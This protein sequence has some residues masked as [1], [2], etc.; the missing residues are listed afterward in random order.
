MD[1]NY[2][3]KYFIGLDYEINTINGKDLLI[4]QY[5]AQIGEILNPYQHNN[6]KQDEKIDHYKL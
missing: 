5:M 3:P 6:I 4:Q 2:Q 1:Y